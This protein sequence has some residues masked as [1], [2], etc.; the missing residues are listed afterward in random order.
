[1]VPLD[2]ISNQNSSLVK[3]LIDA[4][5]RIKAKPWQEPFL[6]PI[7]QIVD[8]TEEA[9]ENNIT[10]TSGEALTADEPKP[11]RNTPAEL[12]SDEALLNALH[13]DVATDLQGESEDDAAA[14]AGKFVK[15]TDL[16]PP[17]PSKGTFDVENIKKSQY[18]FS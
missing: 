10:L 3:Q 1:M 2:N 14:L 16:I 5:T 6:R 13:E 8:Y 12:I 7:S 15:L 4:G 9:D 11:K 18:F 17:L